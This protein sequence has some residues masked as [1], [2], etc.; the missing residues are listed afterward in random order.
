MSF[1][2]T[3]YR[4]RQ[5][6]AGPATIALDVQRVPSP[7]LLHMSTVATRRFFRLT[8]SNGPTTWTVLVWLGRQR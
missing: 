1:L 3:Y 5:I 6:I 8:V 7:L 4:R 2:D